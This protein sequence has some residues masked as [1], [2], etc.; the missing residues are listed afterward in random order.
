[1][2]EPIRTDGTKPPFF[3]VHGLHGIMGIAGIMGRALGP[4]QPLYALHARG[5]DG[6]APPYERMDDMVGGYFAEIRAARPRGP[7]VVGGVCGGGLV[8]MELARAL[9][10]QG[11]RVGSVILMDPPL[12]P[13]YQLPQ[14]RDLDPKADH[15]VYEQLHASTEQVFR[16]FAN[17]FGHLP[18]DVNDPV[19]LRRAIDVGIATMMMFSRYVPPP[20]DGP[21]EFIISSERGFGFFHPKGPWTVIVPKP[22]RFHVLPGI[23]YEFFRKNLAVMLR[24]VQ[25][26]L[27]LAFNG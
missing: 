15:R 11:E 13:L 10:A 14:Y 20:F 25:F 4:D 16:T 9:A 7:Y 3:A 23:H 1:M 8:A 12:I 26:A 24:L 22:G 17:D 19:Q 5:F 21:T 6:A 2:L 18:F 27:D